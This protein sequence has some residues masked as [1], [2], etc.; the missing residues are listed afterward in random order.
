MESSW[1]AD[2]FFCL[3]S[4]GVAL[5]LSVWR[6]ELCYVNYV[7]CQ[8]QLYLIKDLDKSIGGVRQKSTMPWAQPAAMHAD[9]LTTCPLSRPRTQ[10]HSTYLCG[11]TGHGLTLVTA[12]TRHPLMPFTA[13]AEICHPP[14]HNMISTECSNTSFAM[15]SP[16]GPCR[17]QTATTRLQLPRTL[18][19][20]VAT[21]D[22]ADLLIYK[23]RA[24]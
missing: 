16:L 13:F 7:G 22:D 21:G 11:W 14:Q 18:Y 5:Q 8:R 20:C 19:S 10:Q 15:S 17:A 9:V 24:H 4:T 2:L 3:Q 6:R 23:R 12:S 1:P